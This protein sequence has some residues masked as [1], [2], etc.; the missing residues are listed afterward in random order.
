MVRGGTAGALAQSPR[1]A[2][3]QKVLCGCSRGDRQPAG[4]VII[5]RAWRGGAQLGRMY[6]EHGQ[7]LHQSPGSPRARGTLLCGWR[8]QTNPTLAAGGEQNSGARRPFCMGQKAFRHLLGTS[9]TSVQSTRSQDQ[10]DGRAGVAAR[11][12]GA[13]GGDERVMCGETALLCSRPTV[14]PEMLDAPVGVARTAPRP[15][16]AAPIPPALRPA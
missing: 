3:K 7:Q 9:F 4:E 16:S 10:R 13:R 2:S 12:A 8:V 6:L 5:A 15:P 14:E 11:G 1:P